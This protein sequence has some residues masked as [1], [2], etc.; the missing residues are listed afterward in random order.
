M[1]NCDVKSF[2]LRNHG[3]A[4]SNLSNSTLSSLM[5]IWHEILVGNNTWEG[6]KE[7]CRCGGVLRLPEKWPAYTR[8]TQCMQH[9]WVVSQVIFLC[10]CCQQWTCGGTHCWVE[11]DAFRTFTFLNGKL[12][13][14]G[15]LFLICVAA[16]FW[17]MRDCIYEWLSARLQ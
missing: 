4:L 7:G 14:S 3:S 17:Q 5:Q 2:I 16:R 11:A 13:R 8:L 10:L 6:R 15:W 12:G 1:I 9:M